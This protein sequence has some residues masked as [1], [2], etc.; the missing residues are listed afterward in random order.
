MLVLTRKVGESLII[1]DR[2]RITVVKVYEGQVR[3]GVEAPPDVAVYREELMDW[4]P[5]AVPEEA[6]A[7]T[8][9]GGAA[10]AGEEAETETRGG[11][12]G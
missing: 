4:E 3:L 11:G 6:E 2:I 9:G 5:G 7:E 12:A 8:P 10:A 1:G